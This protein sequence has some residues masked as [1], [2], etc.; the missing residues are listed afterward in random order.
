MRKEENIGLRK[1]R[2]RQNDKR[3]R[4]NNNKETRRKDN[5]R[6]RSGVHSCFLLVSG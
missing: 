5:V 2:A 3:G 1:R 6:R 4:E